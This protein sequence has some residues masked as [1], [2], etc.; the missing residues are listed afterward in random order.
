MSTAIQVSD[1]PGVALAPRLG[2]LRPIAPAADLLAAQEEV[3]TLIAQTLKSGRDYGVIPG[4][5][6]PSLLKP[7]AERVAGAF[8]CSAR[9]SLVEQQ[10]D[11][12]RAVPW[13][14]RKK[15]WQG[16]RWTGDW[17]EEH[18][19]SF[20]LYRFAVRCDIV[21]RESGVVVGSCIGV[22][23]TMESKY[24]DRPRDSENTVLKMAQK[25]ALVGAVLGA[26]GLSEQFTQDVEDAG[27]PPAPVF[28]PANGAQIG[29]TPGPVG[30]GPP[31]TEER[32]CPKCGGRT[33]DNRASKLNP[34]A[35]DFKC[36]SKECGGV[37]WPEK[38][39]FKKP[40]VAKAPA[41]E[42]G[43]MTVTDEEWAALDRGLEK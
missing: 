14:K 2:L 16:G 10:V 22:C 17:H 26:F 15:V 38:E 35:P 7:G 39:A 34:K 19:E 33:F 36:R 27:E 28:V 6:K 23:S 8:G 42:P 3:R 21:H 20:G 41:R 12:D 37:I 4:V 13:T 43:D 40:P 24:I 18:G 11:H 30:D 1:E 31:P 25:R 5:D 29:A 32:P 9:Y